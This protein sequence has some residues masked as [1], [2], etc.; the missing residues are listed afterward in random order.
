MTTPVL[1]PIILQKHDNEQKKTTDFRGQ[2][3][4]ALDF[5]ILTC[6]AFTRSMCR[7]SHSS[8]QMRAAVLSPV[9][10]PH[11]FNST[12]LTARPNG[13]VVNVIIEAEI[14]EQSGGQKEEISL[15]KRLAKEA[16]QRST[17]IRGRCSRW[18][19]FREGPLRGVTVWRPTRRPRGRRGEGQRKGQGAGGPLDNELEWNRAKGREWMVLP[20]TLRYSSSLCGHRYL[21]IS[22]R[23]IFGV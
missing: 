19:R 22:F 11:P 4:A 15:P 6:D 14:N 1:E 17:E 18:H 16:S 9:K 8:W 7:R 23:I 2:N 13:R 5:Q 20:Q 12:S 10:G 21:P 3:W